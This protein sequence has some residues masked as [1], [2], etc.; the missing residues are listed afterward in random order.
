MKLT[1][2]L[3]NGTKNASK[4]IQKAYTDLPIALKEKSFKVLLMPFEVCSKGHITSCNKKK[5]ENILKMFHISVKKELFVKLS[6]IS[7]LCTISIF[8]AYQVK[9]LIS[10]P[11]LTP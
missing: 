9:E 11:L 10:P 4:R 8:Y 3:P 2:I 7:L 5:I 6:K 1:C